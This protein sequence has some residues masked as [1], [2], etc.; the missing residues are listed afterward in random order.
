MQSIVTGGV[1]YNCYNCYT[2]HV[3]SQPSRVTAGVRGQHDQA[4]PTVS[5]PGMRNG[6]S[7]VGKEEK[8]K[9]DDKGGRVMIKDRM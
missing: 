8:R 6:D 4:H 3:T 9:C 7:F 1:R 2:L 5:R